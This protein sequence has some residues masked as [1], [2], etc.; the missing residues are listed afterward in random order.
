M[1]VEF[2]SNFSPRISKLYK[3]LYIIIFILCE[4]TYFSGINSTPVNAEGT[5]LVR[6]DIIAV[7]HVRRNTDSS[8]VNYRE[9]SQ[10]ECVSIQ[11]SPKR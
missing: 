8:N 7:M 2:P 10:T 1:I 6:E 11:I 9:S 5:I 4:F 3:V